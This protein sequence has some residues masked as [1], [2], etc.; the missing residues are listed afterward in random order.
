MSGKGTFTAKDGTTFVVEKTG[1]T[2]RVWKVP[3]DGAG[4]RKKGKEVYNSLGGK[5][6][7]FQ[8][9]LAA[10]RAHYNNY[11][12]LLQPSNNN[13]TSQ[14][15]PLEK[16]ADITA[17]QQ[18][19]ETIKNDFSNEIQR[20]A[21]KNNISEPEA[22]KAIIDNPQ[23]LE[24]TEFEKK[25]P[26]ELKDYIDNGVPNDLY[27]S[28]LSFVN[29]TERL[30]DLGEIYEQDKESRSDILGEFKDD[31]LGKREDRQNTETDL[32][33]N[34]GLFG[35]KYKTIADAL[36]PQEPE[37]SFSEKVSSYVPSSETVK[38]YIPSAIS[39][40]F[41]ESEGDSQEE[42][43][44]GVNAP[45][46]PLEYEETPPNPQENLDPDLLRKIALEREG[47]ELKELG[48]R[49]S[50][51]AFDVK[52]SMNFDPTS[53]W[54]TVNDTY[55][56]PTIY[57]S[58]KQYDKKAHQLGIMGHGFGSTSTLE[59]REGKNRARYESDHRAKLDLFDRF[60]NYG[61]IN[62]N[63]WIRMNQE[64]RNSMTDPFKTSA[65]V[66]DT[67]IKRDNDNQYKQDVFR[68]D[69]AEGE[70]SN[71]DKN[72]F[73]ELDMYNTE[74]KMMDQRRQES[75]NT[76]ARL[77]DLARETQNFT[78]LDQVQKANLWAQRQ[79]ILQ[80]WEGLRLNAEQ[81]KAVQEAKEEAKK[82]ASIAFFTKL[83]AAAAIIVA[84]K[85]AGT[86][87]AISI[88]AGG[89]AGNLSR[90][91]NWNWGQGFGTSAS[92][93]SAPVPQVTAGSGGP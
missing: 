85:G 70:M 77:Y 60:M 22:R 90:D 79:Q 92:A 6:G 72:L 30:G 93:Q 47:E 67:A 69:V 14:P 78:N 68:K 7:D 32:L 53:L 63:D 3:P 44:E 73:E 55:Q 26:E 46:N 1:G 74:N 49:Q 81:Q 8:D 31:T 71:Q 52:D 39:N 56:P 10:A 48:R 75:I 65:D 80:G 2:F 23:L 91:G 13:S 4:N 42:I 33:L 36:K 89:N 34:E 51:E 62:R 9:A 37:Q 18:K 21:D 24:G 58:D 28:S 27:I 5:D 76:A 20:Y 61:T 40:F 50:Q 54:D 11:Q 17:D 87:A 35:D 29:Q 12:K 15:T 59:N 19:T 41:G 64:E 43:P 45:P 86:P 57:D 88:M 84:T 83:A 38:S 16:S 25:H 82:G 66:M